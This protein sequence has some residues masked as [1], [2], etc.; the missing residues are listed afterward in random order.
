M[1]LYPI[2]CRCRSRKSTPA[3][4]TAQCPSPC[5]QK[6]RIQLIVQTLPGETREDVRG[7]GDLAGGPDSA[8]SHV[9]NPPR[10]Y[11]RIRFM[12]GTAMDPAHPLVQTMVKCVAGN[13]DAPPIVGAP[14]ACDMFALHQIFG[15]PALLYGP[16]GANAHAADEYIELES[17]FQFAEAL[18]LFVSDWCGTVG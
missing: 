16:T 14:Y 4:G 12:P 10:T 1:R 18:L 5:R 8:A 3:G 9:F 11:H 17:V 6:G 13:G 2:R 15:M 7:A